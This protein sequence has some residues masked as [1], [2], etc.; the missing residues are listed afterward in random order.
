MRSASPPVLDGNVSHLGGTQKP[1]LLHREAAGAGRDSQIS[2]SGYS[3]E[4]A[5]LLRQRAQMPLLLA[6]GLLAHVGTS[7]LPVSFHLV[8]L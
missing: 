8:E 7:C 3:R 6:F 1:G 2:V 5:V 4:E